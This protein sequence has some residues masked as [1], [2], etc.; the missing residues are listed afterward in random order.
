MNETA[1]PSPR[2]LPL[3]ALGVVVGASVLAIFYHFDPSKFGF[4]P[5]CWLHSYTG[6]HCPGCGGQ[7]AVHALLHGD[8]VAACRYNLMLMLVGPYLAWV[9]AMDLSRR[10]RRLPPPI[11]G[12][13]NNRKLWVFFTAMILF[14]ILR[15]IPSPPFNLLAP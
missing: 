8:I 15:N 7:R 11:P 10:A 4:F 14:G 9:G 6:L 12:A 3:V 1:P 2:H 5:R 13:Q